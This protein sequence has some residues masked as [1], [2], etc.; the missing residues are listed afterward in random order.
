MNKWKHLVNNFSNLQKKDKLIR[1][2]I[3]DDVG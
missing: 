2:D 3:S 1:N